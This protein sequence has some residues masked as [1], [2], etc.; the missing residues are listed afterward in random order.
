MSNN[1][2]TMQI[3][4]Y[5]NYHWNNTKTKSIQSKLFQCLFYTNKAL[6]LEHL[7]KVLW[8]Y[9]NSTNTKGS[10]LCDVVQKS[11]GC[12]WRSTRNFQGGSLV[13]QMTLQTIRLW[14]I[15]MI[16]DKSSIIFQSFT[17]QKLDNLRSL[18]HT[19]TSRFYSM[20]L[21]S[22]FVLLI[23]SIYVLIRQ[24]PYYKKSCS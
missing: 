9:L 10:P 6:N 20:I 13:F 7:V 16:F 23:R 15:S 18:K 17:I 12:I 4:C 1:I 24:W 21:L 3:W 14:R 2:N 8:K 19:R 22:N 11:W 5:I